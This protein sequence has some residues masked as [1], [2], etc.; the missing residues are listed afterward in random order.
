M[1]PEEKPMTLRSV[2]ALIVLAFLA[3]PGRVFGLNARFGAGEKEPFNALALKDLN[4]ETTERHDVMY[5]RKSRLPQEFA[6]VLLC[7]NFL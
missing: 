2:S 5:V 7:Y 4:T 1:P 3:A 6:E